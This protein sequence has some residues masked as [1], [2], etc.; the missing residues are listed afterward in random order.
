MKNNK[1]D[2]SRILKLKHIKRNIHNNKIIVEIQEG[3]IK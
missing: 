2:I 1:C 3:I